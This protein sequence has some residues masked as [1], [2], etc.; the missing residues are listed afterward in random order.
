MSRKPKGDGS[1][2]LDTP[3]LQD[4]FME[5]VNEAERRLQ[6]LGLG[7][8][9]RLNPEQAERFWTLIVEKSALVEDAVVIRYRLKPLRWWH[10]WG[11]A[12]HISQ[13]FWHWI[14]RKPP[15]PGGWGAVIRVG[16]LPGE[17]G[18]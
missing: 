10:L 15:P 9:Y 5:Q 6:S 7:Q 1:D 18:E 13:R 12:T 11:W 8:G 2:G 16:R 3:E 17:D 4:E 14:T